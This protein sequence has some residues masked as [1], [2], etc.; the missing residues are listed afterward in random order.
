MIR[1]LIQA[2]FKLSGKHDPQ[3]VRG[4][5]YAVAEGFF[6][7]VPYMLIY[8]L[9]SDLTAGTLKISGIILISGLML[10]A[11]ILRML[12]GIISMPLIF[13]GTYAMMGEARLR[14]ADHL[15]HLPL[16]WFGRQRGGDLS[17]RLTSDLEL[18]EHLWSHFLGIFI[19]GLTMPAFLMLFLFYVDARL[20]CVTLISIP[21]ALLALYWTQKTLA[22]AGSRLLRANADAQAAILEYIQG[23]AVIRGFGRYGQAWKQLEDT[24]TE[25]HNATLEAE[26]RPSPWLAAFGFTLELGYLLIVLAAVYWLSEGTLSTTKLVIFL[27]LALPVYRQLF[28]VGLSTMLLR[29][30]RRALQ[31]IEDLLAEPCIPDTSTPQLPNGQDITF[32]QVSFAYEAKDVLKQL[33]CHIPAKRIT[34]LVGPSGAGKTTLVHLIAR[35]WDVNDGSICIGSTDIR[36]MNSETLYK[37]VSMVF[38]DVVLFSGTLLDNIRIGNPNATEAETIAAARQAQAHEFISALP[39]GYHTVL[40]ENGSSLSGGERQRISIARAL[41]KNAPILLLDE[42]TAS[43]DPSAEADIQHAITQLAKDR[44]VV[45]IAHRLRSICDAD[46]ILVLDQGQLKE[47]GNHD[48]LMALNGLYAK[49]WHQQEAARQWRITD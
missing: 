28:E 9:L 26:S 14:V 13:A 44:T 41:L 6:S 42:A 46:Q 21:F 48:D 40:H 39:D 45:V 37:Q 10:L 27:V 49:L 17:A 31:R 2:G 4:L 35:L 1:E 22:K 5:K 19:A 33:S 11:L 29:F 3:L 12:T 34:A 36:M 18:V 15:R 20:A 32:N 24:L 16:G 43:I 7:A 38:Q 8:W 47:Q 23:I 30:A 25:Q